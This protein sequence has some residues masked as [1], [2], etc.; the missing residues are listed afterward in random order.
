CRDERNEDDRC[1]TD[2]IR[3]DKSTGH[4]CFLWK[5]KTSS[6]CLRLDLY[7]LRFGFAITNR[8]D[9]DTPADVPVMFRPQYVVSRHTTSRPRMLL[10][11]RG[12]SAYLYDPGR[13]SRV[14]SCSAPRIMRWVASCRWTERIRSNDSALHARACE[15]SVLAAPHMSSHRAPVER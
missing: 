5:L 11:N 6:A 8:R 7:Y 12:N 14:I 10:A 9:S 3:S 15:R 13:P 4:G 2:Q 1:T